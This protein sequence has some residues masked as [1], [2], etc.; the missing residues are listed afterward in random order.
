MIWAAALVAYLLIGFMVARFTVKSFENDDEFD[1]EAISFE[2]FFY[3]MV[4]VTVFWFFIGLVMLAA[5]A[6]RSIRG[7]GNERQQESA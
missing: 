2:T 3:M 6:V 1:T 7:S 5:V 4:L